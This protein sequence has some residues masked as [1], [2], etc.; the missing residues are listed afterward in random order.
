VRVEDDPATTIEFDIGQCGPYLVQEVRHEQQHAVWAQVD[1]LLRRDD[2]DPGTGQATTAL[3]GDASA[4]PT[5]SAGPTPAIAS[6]A[7]DRDA[8]PYPAVVS[9]AAA[10]SSR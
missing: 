7:T 10:H 4:I 5:R 3:V 1:K 2:R 6:R 8:A 9:P